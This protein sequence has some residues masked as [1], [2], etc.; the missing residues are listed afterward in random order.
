MKMF[1]IS[2]KV[3]VVTGAGQGIGMHLSNRL[4]ELGAEVIA[5]DK[6]FPNADYKFDIRFVGDP[7]SYT[8][9]RAHET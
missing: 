7:V 8:H 6:S 3:I 2:D 5:V 1:D 9:L 4:Y